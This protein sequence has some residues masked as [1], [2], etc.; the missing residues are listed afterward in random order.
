MSTLR[1]SLI[2]ELSAIY[3]GETHLVKNMPKLAEAAEDPDLKEALQTH[4][5]ETED[6]VKRLE[7]LFQELDISP[8]RGKCRPIETLVQEAAETASESGSDAALLAAAQKIEHYEI[9]TYQ[10]LIAWARALGEEEALSVLEEILDE[11]ELTN[12]KLTEIADSSVIPD[13][14][15]EEHAEDEEE[16]AM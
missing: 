3:C 9:A 5:S 10:A 7:E 14:V 11:E 4:H 16:E 6:Q 1:D 13:A 15:G 2:A 12:E 8:K